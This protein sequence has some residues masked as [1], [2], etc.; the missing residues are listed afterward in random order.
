M[1]LQICAGFFSNAPLRIYGDSNA[2]CYVISTG[3][4][5]FIA[6]SIFAA[7]AANRR[8]DE[9]MMKSLKRMKKR[10]E[11]KKNRQQ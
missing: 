6:I 3:A 1:L 8:R 4:I 9:M 5:L 10:E 7:K 2:G 11:I